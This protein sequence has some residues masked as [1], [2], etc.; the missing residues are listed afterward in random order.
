[1]RNMGLKKELSNGGFGAERFVA[2]LFAL[3]SFG[4]YNTGYTA[5]FTRPNPAFSGTSY[6]PKT[7]SEIAR[8]SYGNCQMCGIQRIINRSI[9]EELL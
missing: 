4:S 1:M 7:L 2:S 9:F 6:S 8:I 5:R 3:T